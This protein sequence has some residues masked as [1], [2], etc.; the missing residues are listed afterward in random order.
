MRKTSNQIEKNMKQN[1]RQVFKKGLLITCFL[2]IIS[3]FWACIQ[4]GSY[5]LVPKKRLDLAAYYPEMPP[6]S[7]HIYIELPIDHHNPDLGKYKGFYLLSPAFTHKKDVIFYLTDGQQNKVNTQSDFNIFEQKLPGLSYVVMGRRGSYPA[8]FPEVYTKDGSLDYKKAMNLYGT[9]QQIE[10]IEMVRQDL[11]KKG[12]LP[13]DGKIMLSGTSGGGILIQEYLAKYGDHV[14]RVLLEA[15]GAPDIVI[16]NKIKN[17]GSP[18][19]DVMKEESPKTLKK[20]EDILANNK[21]NGVALCYMLYKIQ[22][23]DIDWKNTCINLIDEIAGGNKC[24]YYKNLF[25]PEYNF[26]LSNFLMRFPMM[27]S[28]K[29][30]IFELTG[31]QLIKYLETPGDINITFEWEKVMVQDYLKQAKAGVIDV[32]R[33]NLAED[34]KKYNGEV[35]LLIGDADNQFSVKAAE[36]INKSYPK[37]KMVLVHDTHAMLINEKGYQN[38]RTAFFTKGLYAEELENAIRD[39]KLNRRT[40]YK[41]E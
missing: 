12:Y 26:S 8:L 9:E 6:D 23:Y 13:P 18:F 15:T 17:L 40:N 36:V 16:D 21:V 25:N 4:Y 38:L 37:S 20:L 35:L 7:S 33:I 3:L 1:N 5:I 10:D 27:D 41:S 32:P 2:L 19:T 34:R 28:T 30:R 22:L 11:E 39:E 29:V 31:E 24:N 14:S